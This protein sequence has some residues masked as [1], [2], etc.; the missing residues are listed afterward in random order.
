MKAKNIVLLI[1]H[2]FIS[3]QIFSELILQPFHHFTYITTD[4]PT[5]LSL[6]LRHSS[7]SNPS[8]ASPMS[9]FTLQ[10]FFCFSYITSSSLPG[11]PPM[12]IRRTTMIT[13]S[14]NRKAKL[15]SDRELCVLFMKPEIPHQ[16]LLFMNVIKLS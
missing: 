3:L 4:S 14:N 13:R 5:L 9:Q 16:M 6:Y 10:H 11:E 2:C 15:K 12:L 7:F 8:I 1:I